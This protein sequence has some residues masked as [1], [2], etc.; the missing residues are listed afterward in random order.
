MESMAIH[1]LGSLLCHVFGPRL[2]PVSHSFSSTAG[3]LG[4][5]NTASTLDTVGTAG[6]ASTLETAGI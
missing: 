6:I 5:L 2:P 4:T 3:T 1:S